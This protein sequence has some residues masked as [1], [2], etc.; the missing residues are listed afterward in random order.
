MDH[1]SSKQFPS[2]FQVLFGVLLM[3]VGWSQNAWAL[4]TERERCPDA[5]VKSVGEFFRLDHFAYPKD[6]YSPSVE[7]G[8]L[9][10]AGVCKPLPNDA[11]R[12]IAAFAYDAGVEYEKKL[13][14]V[15]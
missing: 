5:I 3:A 14:L 2:A 4:D 15:V 8:G 13:L 7:N 9:I 10:V 12:V 1:P 11:S 6:N